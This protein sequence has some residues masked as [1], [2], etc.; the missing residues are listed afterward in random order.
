MFLG[1]IDDKRD[2]GYAKDYVEAMYLMLQQ[3]Q[4]DDYIISTGETHSVRE[5]LDVAFG[6]VSLDWHEYVRIDEK[7]VRPLDHR[8][9]IF[10]GDNSKAKK[11]LNWKPKTSFDEL[12]KL[13]VE[14]DLKEKGISL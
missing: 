12:V 1:N 7:L 5:F 6:L 3:K 2:W 14:A 10:Q 11:I 13:M 4:P 9:V 8:K